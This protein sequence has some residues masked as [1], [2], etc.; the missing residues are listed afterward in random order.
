MVT[1]I[2]EKIPDYS[3]ASLKLNNYFLYYRTYPKWAIECQEMYST[4]D[5]A[6]EG[7]KAGT[8]TSSSK[9]ILIVSIIAFGI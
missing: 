9:S 1:K 4:N 8:V 2:R 5:F 3:E 7:K 6:E